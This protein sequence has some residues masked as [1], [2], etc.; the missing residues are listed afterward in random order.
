LFFQGVK[1]VPT[2]IL[3]GDVDQTPRLR[4]D[5]RYYDDEQFDRLVRAEPVFV[6]LSCSFSVFTADHWRLYHR[7]DEALA[8]ASYDGVPLALLLPEPRR[9]MTPL[10][11]PIKAAYGP[12]QLE[13]AEW[14]RGTGDG[15]L[16]ITDHHS[17]LTT[18]HSLRTKVELTYDLTCRTTTTDDYWLWMEVLDAEG[19]R[20]QEFKRGIWQ[21]SHPTS[22]WFAGDTF[23]LRETVEIPAATEDSGLAVD[24]GLSPSSEKR[25]TRWIRLPP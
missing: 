24:L 14:G 5:L 4:R 17:P 7:R 20:I 2:G 8:S 9:E 21:P 3:A 12:L 22:D 15:G 13:A 19:R 11:H 18:H 16:G 10:A 1:K 23:R 25:P 6:V